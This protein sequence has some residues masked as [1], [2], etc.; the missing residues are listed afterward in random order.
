MPDARPLAVIT[1]ASRGIGRAV[2]LRL[3]RSHDVVAIARNAAELDTL[4]AEIERGEGGG[5]GGG[6]CRTIPLD[7]TDHEAVTA[8]LAGIEAD[9]LV[10]NAG[11]GILKP[12]ME[13]TIEEWR[14]MVDLN[15]TALYSVTRALLPA[16]L[17]RESGHVVI[18]GSISGRSAFV[19]GTCYGGTKHA[20]MG[21]SESLMLEVRD[22]GV[23]VSVVNPGSVDT[24]FF[25]GGRRADTWWMLHADDVAAAV[26][27]VLHTPQQVLLHRVEVRALSTKRKR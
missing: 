24:D 11:V 5:G 1:G 18:I 16:M 17:A 13:L 9:V 3:A 23:K 4:R 15:F 10:N 21:F 25:A 12:F 19:G 22:R 7:L 8:A 26:E 6:R 20:V 27:A 14:A 2:A